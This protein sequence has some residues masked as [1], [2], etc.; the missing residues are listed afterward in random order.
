MQLIER[1]IGLLSAIFLLFFVL[2]LVRASKLMVVDHASFKAQATGQ[3]VGDIR[4]PAPRGAILDRH[5]DELAVSTDAADVSATPYL[6]KDPPKASAQ[7]AP[8]LGQTAQQIAAKLADR[9]S[10]FV[11]L[12][13]SVP[14]SAV[15]KI[16]KLELAGIDTAPT[17]TRQYPGKTMAAQVLGF[18]G[19]E[20]KGL[21][22]L[23][24]RWEKQLHGSDGER[25]VVKDGQG[26][27]IS[28]VDVA[29]V[30]PGQNLQL[31]LDSQL[32]L[33]TESVLKQVAATYSPK[34]ASAIVMDPRDGSI[35][36]MANYPTLDANDPGEAT[37]E[38][39]Q[40]RAV[41]FNYEPGST[42]K[43]VTVA[44]ALTDKTVTPSTVFDLPV[45]LQV[46]DR[47]VSDSEERGPMALPVSEIIAK[48][49]NVGTVKIAQT[50][51][52]ESFDQ[53]VHK[54]G[55]G[56][57]TGVDLAGEEQGLVLGH[58]E[59][60][61]VSKANF[62]IGQGL[63][64][65]PIQVAA[66]YSAIANGGILRPPHI[67]ESVGG[68]PTPAPEGS[69]VITPR[70]SAQLRTMLEGVISP[71]GTA[72]EAA[73]P[74]YK[75]AGKT[76]TAEIFDTELGAYSKSKYVASFIGFA[77]AEDPELLVSVVVDQPQGEI[78][79]GKIAAPAF[80]Q[81]LNFALPYLK[82]PPK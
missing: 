22:G 60:S 41:G 55:F 5:G 18:V 80:Q 82:I 34:G 54:F 67:V 53:W 46:E 76:G 81:I 19:T 61:G 17:S 65:T 63:S 36:A 73:I 49:S 56:K 52:D 68:T 47:V 75:L 42:F 74:G 64:V 50:M 10:G 70:V 69:R 40:N 23:E 26:E 30:Q 31:T 51:K 16:A 58:K 57:P 39:L 3:Q 45:N 11:Y 2:A 15:A 33:H 71:G 4:V 59:Y 43:G 1:R 48:S 79:G 14:G 32:Q 12:A 62:A 37:P 9:K 44:G 7:L 8:L 25:R 6:V 66:A 35:L 21:S 29:K 24:Y 27:A 77:P 20:G 28:T 38:A 13:R 72:A 78:Y